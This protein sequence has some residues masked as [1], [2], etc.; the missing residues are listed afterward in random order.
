MPLRQKAFALFISIFILLLIVELIRRRKLR[1]E[2]S[3]LWFLAGSAMIILSSF[4]DL[5]LFLTHLIGALNSTS[6][7]FF[8]SM[9]FIIVINIHYA[10]KLS[11]LSEQ[12]RNLAQELSLLEVRARG[13]R[14]PLEPQ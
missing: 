8:L 9:G 6:T 1:E 7:L 13:E 11:T 4:Y 14:E 2:Y 10:V 5:L 12:V 3:W